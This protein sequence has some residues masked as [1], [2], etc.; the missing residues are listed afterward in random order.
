MTTGMDLSPGPA[1][2][3]P[4]LSVLERIKMKTA[5]GDGRQPSIVAAASLIFGV[6]THCIRD[7]NGAGVRRTTQYSL[8][9][10]ECLREK[11]IEGY[12]IFRVGNPGNRGHRRP[13]GGATERTRPP[14]F[15]TQWLR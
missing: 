7:C 12:F 8:F 5:P 6:P 13:G 10:G 15:S 14:W 2:Q 11:C 9:T 4:H 1:T 3:P